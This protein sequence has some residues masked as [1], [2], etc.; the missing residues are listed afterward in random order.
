LPDENALTSLE[1]RWAFKHNYPMMRDAVTASICANIAQDQHEAVLE[2]VDIE[3]GGTGSGTHLTPINFLRKN[4]PIDVLL[5]MHALPHT[6]IEALQILDES[7]DR[8]RQMLIEDWDLQL[9]GVGNGAVLRGKLSSRLTDKQIIHAFTDV[10]HIPP[11]DSSV[12]RKAVLL[13]TH[14]KQI[15]QA[16]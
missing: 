8:L 12:G 11:V 1:A 4:I 5:V 7:E 3:L 6:D 16:D 10:A 2:A 15:L 13:S 14:S 9:G